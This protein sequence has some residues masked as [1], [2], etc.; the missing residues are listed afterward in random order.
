MAAP[1]R[2]IRLLRLQRGE[3]Q[4][5]SAAAVGL[6]QSAISRIECGGYD[7][8]QQIRRRLAEHFGRPYPQLIGVVSDVKESYS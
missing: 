1:L 5:V 4:T 6:S 2:L 7:P 3:T 8:E